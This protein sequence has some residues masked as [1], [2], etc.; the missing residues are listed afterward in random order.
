M[1]DGR[2]GGAIYSQEAADADQAGVSERS[3]LYRESGVTLDAVDPNGAQNTTAITGQQYW[4][5]YSAIGENYVYGQD[6]VRLREFSL[7]YNVPNVSSLGIESMNIALIGRNLF[8][9]SKKAEDIDPESMLGTNIS[10]QGLSFS[11]L[12]TQRSLGLN[13]TLKF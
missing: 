10:G 9:F 4:Q 3:L 13:V 11:S 6:N 5:S 7:G 8:F 12:P 1:I 2:F